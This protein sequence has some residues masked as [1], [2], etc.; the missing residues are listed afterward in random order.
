MLRV[1]GD[2][3]CS[4]AENEWVRE[5]MV[6]ATAWEIGRNR[7]RSLWVILQWRKWG[8]Q[9]RDDW[10]QSRDNALPLWKLLKMIKSLFFGGGGVGVDCFGVFFPLEIYLVC[11]ESS[12]KPDSI[13]FWFFLL[14]T[15]SIM[16][17]MTP[18]VNETW[19]AL[20]QNL[21]LYVYALKEMQKETAHGEWRTL[22]NLENLHDIVILELFLN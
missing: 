12:Y 22:C 17:F 6:R 19:L 7:I 15:E 11:A 10:T 8:L 16:K 13:L 3:R 21:W 20:S 5:R 9:N 14:K 1:P 4:C 18:Y 2:L